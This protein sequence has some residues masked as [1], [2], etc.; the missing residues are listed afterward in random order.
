MRARESD[1]VAV[2]RRKKM[3]GLRGGPASKILT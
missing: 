1:A 2:L 3:L